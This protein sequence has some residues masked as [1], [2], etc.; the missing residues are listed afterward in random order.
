VLALREDAKVA[1][2]SKALEKAAL[3]EAERACA[4]QG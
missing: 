3:D 1:L 4:L 2:L